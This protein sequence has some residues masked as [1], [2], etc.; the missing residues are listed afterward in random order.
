LH[1]GKEINK[2]QLSRFCSIACHNKTIDLQNAALMQ[3]EIYFWKSIVHI[4]NT[5]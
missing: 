1:T 5:V 4:Q 3:T 2:L